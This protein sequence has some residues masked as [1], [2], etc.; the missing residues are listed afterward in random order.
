MS[1]SITCP[2][3]RHSF[4]PSLV[5]RER[6][7]TDLRKKLET[8]WRKSLEKKEAQHEIELES[9]KAELAAAAKAQAALVKKTRDL[10]EAARAAEVEIERRVSAE[11]TRVRTSTEKELRERLGRENAEVVRAKEQEL[12]EA[13]AKLAD[14][15]KKQLEMMRKESALA[16]RESTLELHI[17]QQ[18]DSERASLRSKIEQEAQVRYAREAAEK[19]RAKEQELA[20]ANKRLEIAAKTEAELIERAGQL[21]EMQRRAEAEMQKR[22][23]EDG[24]KL[25]E[26]LEKEAAIQKALLEA[27]HQQRLEQANKTIETLKQKLHQGSQ[28]TQG[29]AQEVVL[30]E[31][32]TRA[33]PRDLVEDVAKGVEGA[34]LVQ[35]VRDDA[36]NEAGSILWESKRTKAWSD[37]WLAKMRDDQRAQGATHAVIVTSVMPAGLA[38]FGER[39]GVWICTPAFA[40]PLGEL[41][42]TTLIEIGDARRA[43][44]GR[45]EK[46]MVLYQYLSGP[47]FKAHIHSA[48]ETYVEMQAD[49]E[50]EQRSIQSMW[51]RREQQMR[52]A[53]LSLSAF[54]GDIRGI[55]GGHLIEPI[56]AFELPDGG[57][58]ALSAASDDDDDGE[59]NQELVELFYALV[60]EN[61][62]VGNGTLFEQLRMKARL[63][64]GLEIVDADYQRCKTVLI[65]DGRLEKGKGRGGS[66]R[67]AERDEAAE[68]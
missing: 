57:S 66:V 23:Q 33:F 36:G 30:A 9:K 63:Q 19:V 52:R 26:S 67:R 15:A 20:D 29:E 25:R 16:E 13:R 14:A 18:L 44:E 64:L 45:T 22:V 49:L 21:A 59:A 56:E 48:L 31:V 32:I 6:L 8:E 39:N 50:R 65:A 5:M 37:G 24:R 11:A 62:G 3:C 54:Y 47:Q 38:H 2:K 28:Q 58:P 35:T 61:G 12:A 17:A 4:E 46:M 1:E 60:P 27:E 7:E 40:V 51:K 10:E 34:D 55:A 42:R 68:E 53:R 41:L 43:S